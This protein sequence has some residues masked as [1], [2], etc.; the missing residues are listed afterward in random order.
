MEILRSDALQAVGN[1]ATWSV[2]AWLG[3]T[4]LVSSF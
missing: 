4:V 1:I 3:V 2:I